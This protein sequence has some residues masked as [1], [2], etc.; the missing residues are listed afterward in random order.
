MEWRSDTQLPV[1]WALLD[2]VYR[3]TVHIRCFPPHVV[4]QYNHEPTK[5]VEGD[6]LLQRFIQ[7][8][9]KRMPRL[10]RHSAAIKQLLEVEIRQKI[11]S[12]QRLQGASF[13]TIGVQLETLSSELK[14]PH[15]QGDTP[16]RLFKLT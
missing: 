3:E 2:W 16:E 5:A 7:L 8:G 9:K 1:D 11:P 10:W 14:Y 13:V 6:W 12:F 4:E 15:R